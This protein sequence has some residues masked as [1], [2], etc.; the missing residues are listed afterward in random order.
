MRTFYITILALLT[1]ALLLVIGSVQAQNV[2]AASSAMPVAPA[3]TAMPAKPAASASTAMSAAPAATHKPPV[4]IQAQFTTGISNRTPGDDVTTL[5][6]NHNKIFFFTV[7]KDADGQTITH[8]WEFNGKTVAEVTLQP[9]AN[10]WRTWSSKTLLPDQTGTWTVEVLDDNGKVLMSKSFDYTQ[11]P[12][13]ESKATHTPAAMQSTP[14]PAASAS[15]HAAPP[16]T[17]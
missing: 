17:L 2:P 15:T 9:K 8:R 11:A 5:D 16:P 4:V 7:L 13:S 10:H 1:A 12:V 3:S 6:N 14:T